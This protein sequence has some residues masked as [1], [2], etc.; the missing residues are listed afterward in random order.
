MSAQ[1]DD[2]FE[3]VYDSNRRLLEVFN[4]TLSLNSIDSNSLLFNESAVLQMKCT[5]KVASGGRVS[6]EHTRLA[7]ELQF[8]CRLVHSVCGVPMLSLWQL[9]LIMLD[10]RCMNT[11]CTARGA[12]PHGGMWLCPGCVNKKEFTGS[13]WEQG[14][15]DFMQLPYEKRFKHIAPM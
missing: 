11:K 12:S 14:L 13:S 15:F 10:R 5:G 2:T 6:D 4:Q 8:F 3:R 1:K 9:M 7:A